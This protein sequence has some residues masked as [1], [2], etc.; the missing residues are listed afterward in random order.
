FDY[1][2]LMGY[3]E[4]SI[5]DQLEV[6]RKGETDFIQVGFIS[7]NPYLSVYVVNT[8]ADDFINSYKERSVKNQNS[9]KELLDSLLQGKEASMNAKNSQVKDFQVKNQVINLASQAETLSGQIAEKE[10][11]RAS[12]VGEIQSLIGAISGI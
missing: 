5:L 9:S 3:G 2:Q 10:S 12:A 8:V 4:A 6:V 11:S 7:H 1:L